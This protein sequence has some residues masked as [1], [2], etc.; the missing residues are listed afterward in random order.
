MDPAQSQ[1]LPARWEEVTEH[2]DHRTDGGRL[3]QMKPGTSSSGCRSQVGTFSNGT[4]SQGS[5]T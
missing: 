3:Q 4:K 2:C 1:V 5:D